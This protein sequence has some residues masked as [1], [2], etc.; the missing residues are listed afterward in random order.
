M[1]VYLLTFICAIFA[2]TQTLAQKTLTFWTNESKTGNIKVYYN[3]K[4]AGTITRGYSSFPGCG[5]R[6]CVT[7]TVYGVNNTYEAIAEDGSHWSSYATSLDAPC[8]GMLLSGHSSTSSSSSSNDDDSNYGGYIPPTGPVGPPDHNGAIIALG[9]LAAAAAVVGEVYLN[10]DLYIVAPLSSNYSGL[11]F[12]FRNNWNDHITF[13]QTAVWHYELPSQIQFIDND[14]YF[15]GRSDWGCNARLI[16]NF[17]ER[18]KFWNYG[19]FILN[20]YVGFGADWMMWE[21][22]F[23]S[24]VAGF[25]FGN[26]IVKMDCRYTFGY[27]FRHKTIPINQ[28]Q[29]GLIITYQLN[30][31]GFF[32]R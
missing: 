25:T 24:A 12:G 7:V 22:F 9:V 1:R 3:G 26:E 19:Q 27:D 8:T 13:E 14:S 6:G 30:K 10:S 16:Y 23:T 5:A 28:I 21:G 29:L 32:H 18:D 31:F 15:P 20:P 2:I 11:E 4:Y 17:F